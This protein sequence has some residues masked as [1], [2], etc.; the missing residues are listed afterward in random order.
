MPRSR[1]RLMMVFWCRCSPGLMP[2]KSQVLAR[3]AEVFVCGSASR[4]ARTIL[5]NGGGIWSRS[6]VKLTVNL[7]SV[8]WICARRI[9]EMR[10]SD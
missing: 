9:R 8:S 1:R 10:V 7:P 5:S 2:G 4:C 3:C 6:S